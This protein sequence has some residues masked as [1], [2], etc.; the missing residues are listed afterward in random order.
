MRLSCKFSLQ[1]VFD[2]RELNRLVRCEPI[3][4][5]GS[6]KDGV[7]MSK[8][9]PISPVSRVLGRLDR[10]APIEIKGGPKDGF[11]T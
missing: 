6:L 5:K 11:P 4:S 9:R 1:I 7:P 8:A 2:S 3:E 10:C